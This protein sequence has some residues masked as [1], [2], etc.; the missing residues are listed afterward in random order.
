MVFLFSEPRDPAVGAHRLH[1]FHR[2]PGAGGDRFRG[3]GRTKASAKKIDRASDTLT[4][5][6]RLLEVVLDFLVISSAYYFAL[7]CAMNFISTIL[8]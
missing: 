3:G 5:K 4:Y 2:V 8:S 6:R 1:S 7:P